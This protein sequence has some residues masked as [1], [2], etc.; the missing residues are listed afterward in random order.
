MAMALFVFGA[1][2]V[3]QENLQS[4]FQQWGDQVQINAYL[5][6]ALSPAEITLLHDRI[7]NFP[8]VERVRYISQAQAWKDFQAA[9]GS[10]SNL[11]EGLSQ[12]VLPPS[13]EIF[14]KPF[15]RDSLLVETLANRLRKEKGL[16]TVEYPQES[17][18]R[19]SLGILIVEWAKWAIGAI[20]FMITFL[21]V[22]SVVRLGI[23]ARKDEIELLQWLGA[24]EELIQAPFVVEGLIQG[25]IAAGLSL[26]CLWTLLLLLRDQLLIPFGFFGSSG[27]LRFIDWSGVALVLGMGGLL[28][29][30]G[31]LFSL[32]RFMK[33][34]RR[35]RRETAF[36]LLA[37]VLFCPERLD[38]ASAKDLE[39]IKHRIAKEKQGLREA[40]KR[41]GAI[42][43]ALNK[44][45]RDLEKKTKDLNTASAKVAAIRLE[46]KK[47]EIEKERLRLS[48]DERRKLLVQRAVAIYRWHRGETRWVGLDSDLSLGVLLRRKHYLASTVSFDQEL[49]QQLGD[50]VAH[51]AKVRSELGQRKEELDGERRTLG[52]LRDSIRKEAESK[53][54]LL[55][56][57]TQEK[58]SR[59]RALK[60]LEQAAL[61]LQKMM[62]EMSRRAVSKPPG[63]PAGAGLEAMRGKLEWPVRGQ[64]IGG[65]GKTKHREFSAE[66]FRNGIDIEAPMGEEIRAVEK[67]RVVFAERFAGYG[68]MVIVDHGERY[69]S[70]YAH[71]SEIVKKNGSPVSR[72]EALGRV[73]DSD[74]LAGAK[75]YFEMRK[76]GKSID[77]LPWFQK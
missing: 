27:Q 29:A 45:D 55:A 13:F 31:S 67:G 50:E 46:I 41:E 2:M 12:D 43:Q 34:W 1:F 62:D 7:Q 20:L 68:R 59:V 66:V 11:L 10:Q 21:I 64:I 28:G 75:L 15:H 33:T 69:F 54:R 53:K 61:R 22:G 35:V 19:I 24:S 5:D 26:L 4:M 47:Q 9:L 48:L 49:I 23:A 76:D 6:K 16:T 65:F 70:V 38:A 58:E 73:G 74:S 14:V 71:L 57:L 44:I 40:K 32:R 56:S 42:L 30:S 37:A 77:P 8:E 36:C 17:V 3:A 72:G 63:V 51:H 25:V 18:D 52:Q 60:E 39:G